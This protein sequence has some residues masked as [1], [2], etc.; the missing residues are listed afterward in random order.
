MSGDNIGSGDYEM[1][2]MSNT[3]DTDSKHS[4]KIAVSPGEPCGIGPDITIAINQLQRTEINLVY[5]DPKIIADRAKLLNVKLDIVEL[6][7]VEHARP[8]KPGTIQIVPV[9]SKAEVIPGQPNPNNSSYVLDCLNQAIDACSDSKLDAITTGPISKEVINQAGVPFSGHTQYLADRLGSKR[10]VMMLVSGK[11]RVVLLTTHI[12]LKDVPRSITS[13]L[14]KYVATVV[15]QELKDKFGISSPNIWLC[16]LNPHAGEGGYLGHEEITVI[17]PSAIELRNAGIKITGPVSADSAFTESQR[18]KYDAIIS[19]YHDQ[20]LT[21]LKTLSF[22]EA[23]N[24][25]LGIPIIRTSVDHGTGLDIAGTGK[26][27]AGSL[28]A[29][30]DLA[31]YIVKTQRSQSK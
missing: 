8:H 18:Q 10:P 16:G 9:Q 13:S 12:P 4:L 28:I 2:P 7:G 19:M 6:E 27:N 17:S 30:I 3:A 1:K 25:T 24:V 5:A 29:A 23:V 22:G 11:L 26:S 21:A 31:K 15:H 20:G 14:I